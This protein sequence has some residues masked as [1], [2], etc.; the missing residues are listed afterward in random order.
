MDLYA[1]VVQ[2]VYKLRKIS[3]AGFEL[4]FLSLTVS[5]T[6]AEQKPL[7]VNGLH[8]MVPEGTAFISSKSHF[9]QCRHSRD[10]VGMVRQTDRETDIQTDGFSAL[11]SSR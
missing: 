10:I 11:Y 8:Y 4:W 6:T 9:H 7:A 1:F 5:C 2:K 3:L